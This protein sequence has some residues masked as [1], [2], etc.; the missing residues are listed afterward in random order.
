M[1]AVASDQAFLLDLTRLARATCFAFAA[2]MILSGL[3]EA[4]LDNRMLEFVKSKTEVSGLFRPS[5]NLK[6]YVHA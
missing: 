4:V 2:P 5:P 3:Y 6:S 1:Q